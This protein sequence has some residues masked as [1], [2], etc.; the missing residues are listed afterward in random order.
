M[1]NFILV[2]EPRSGSSL[3]INLLKSHPQLNVYNEFLSLFPHK[4][5]LEKQSF[6]TNSNIINLPDIDFIN[7]FYTHSTNACFKYFTIHNPNVLYFLL[8]NPHINIVFLQRTNKLSQIVSFLQ[9]QYTD[10]WSQIHHN[11]TLTLTPDVINNFIPWFNTSL[12]FLTTLIQ[13]HHNV[14]CLDY[15]SLFVNDHIDQSLFHNLFSFLNVDKHYVTNN[16]Y[17][18]QELRTLDKIISNY[19]YITS[20][21]PH[22]LNFNYFNFISTYIS[23]S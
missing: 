5:L 3:T 14:F 16:T 9:A 17:L 15:E 19:N 13:N 8:E 22:F 11:Q 20:I 23:Y 12:H 10:V 6:T 4:Q 21:Y 2:S 1:N 18:K 7:Y